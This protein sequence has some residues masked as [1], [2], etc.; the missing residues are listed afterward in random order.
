MR[1]RLLAA[2]VVVVLSMPAAAQIRDEPVMKVNPKDGMTYVWIPPGSF[3]LGCSPGDADC[4]Y[5]EKPAR[6]VTIAK[7]FW[8]GQTA[9]TVGAWKRYVSVTSAKLPFPPT[10]IFRQLNPGWKED[11]QPITMVN[12]Q[13]ARNFCEWGGGRL[14]TE[15]EWEYAARAGTTGARYGKLDS[16]AWYADNSGKERIDSRQIVETD[17]N[18]YDIR[19][20]ENE[21]RPHPVAQ[22]EP[23][24]WNLYDMLGNV[25][26][27]TADGNDRE[28]VMRGGSWKSH[29]KFVRASYRERFPT[30]FHYLDIGF[31]CAAEQE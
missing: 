11:Q 7:G 22:K 24:P 31:R 30:E 20:F 6:E 23:N 18:H 15:R 12:W 17:V 8:L 29:S 26:Q 10:F 1:H 4:R 19:L 16:I 3:R 27:W 14:P 25:F 13:K 5:D 21:N 28:R 9:I 2:L